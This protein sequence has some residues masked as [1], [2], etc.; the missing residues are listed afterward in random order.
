MRPNYL[1]DPLRR[2]YHTVCHRFYFYLPM[3]MFFL[4]LQHIRL[5]LNKY[6]FSD[7][8]QCNYLLDKGMFGE[9]MTSCDIQLCANHPTGEEKTR[10]SGENCSAICI[11]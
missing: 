6:G 10:F 4:L 9:L 3:M 2:Y 11:L 1:I 5:I 8:A 7:I